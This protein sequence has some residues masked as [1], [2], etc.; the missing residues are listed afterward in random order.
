MHGERLVKIVMP[1]QF[2]KGKVILEK[3][4]ALKGICLLDIR[5]TENPVPAPFLVKG[6][7]G[8]VEFTDGDE[9]FIQEPILLQKH[10]MLFRIG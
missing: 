10:L 6:S 1:L 2:L 4:K 8:P 9:F 7:F 5:G 3:V